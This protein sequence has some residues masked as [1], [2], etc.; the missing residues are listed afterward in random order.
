MKWNWLNSLFRGASNPPSAMAVHKEHD[1]LGQGYKVVV[2]SDLREID[3]WVE[4]DGVLSRGKTSQLYQM[5]I[6]DFRQSKIECPEAGGNMQHTVFS[7]AHFSNPALHAV[8]RS[9]GGKTLNVHIMN[10]RL[11][12][13][14]SSPENRQE[15]LNAPDSGWRFRPDGNHIT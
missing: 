7:K 15:L 9:P 12:E 4:K 10:A 11:E 3:V 1:N 14:L 8:M 6:N 5:L 13:M 2:E